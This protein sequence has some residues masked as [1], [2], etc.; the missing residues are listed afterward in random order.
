MDPFA[1]WSGNAASIA[2]ANARD[3]QLRAHR[4][5]QKNV[6]LERRVD[7]LES[8]VEELRWTVKKLTDYAHMHCED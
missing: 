2:D 5:A 6:D 1:N 7:E 8:L 3:A 4:A